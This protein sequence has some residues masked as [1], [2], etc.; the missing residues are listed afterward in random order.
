V[1]ERGEEGVELVRRRV[2]LRRY[3][4]SDLAWSPEGRRLLFEPNSASPA[5]T[6]RSGSL[7]RVAVNGERPRR[8]SHAGVR[9]VDESPEW[10]P[11]G[12]RIAFER[13]AWNAQ[14]EPASYKILVMNAEGSHVHAIAR[15]SG[16]DVLSPPHWSPDSRSLA[17]G[18][19]FDIRVANATTGAVERTSS[20]ARG[21]QDWQALP[22]GHPT[23]CADDQP[24]P[25]DAGGPTSG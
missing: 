24:A 10:S 23:R 20:S 7:W 17:F 14:D 22:N 11:D 13:F 19:G 16:Y 6:T 3:P 15:V 25:L 12:Q 18:I 9:Q 2:A 21:L 8:L 5:Y 1:R 4:F